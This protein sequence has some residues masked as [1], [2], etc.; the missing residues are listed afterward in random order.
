MIQTI[1]DEIKLRKDYLPTEQIKSVYFGGGTPSLLEAAELD[2]IMETLKTQFSFSKVAEI[3]LEA[4]PD[5]IDSAKLL[6]WRNAGI[7]RLSIGIQS[8][9]QSDLDWMNR[10]HNVN[11]A[12]NSV[13]MSQDA[14]FEN[15]TV[16]LI[17]GLPDLSLEEWEVHLEKVTSMGIDHISSYCLTVE[18]RTKLNSW[19]KQGKIKPSDE[20]AQSDQFL[21]MIEYLASK[22]FEQYEI[23][24]FAR[25]GRYAVHNTAYWTG[26]PYLGIG[27]SAHSFNGF[28]RRWNIANNS[29]YIRSMGVNEDWFFT[30]ELTTMDRWNEM[31]LTGLRTIFGLHFSSLAEISPITQEWMTK[32]C[33]FEDCGWLMI[34]QNKIILTKEGRLKADYIASEL[35]LV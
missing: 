13:R 25:S 29:A 35:F 10:A 12:E 16:D 3:T 24:N 1:I 27:P 32:V 33:E 30:E 17:Y 11:Q 34:A 28:E 26:A 18:D 9:R 2:R 15:L 31:V 14:G 8:F 19:V 4:N 20:A 23:S 6:S 7:N 21:F 5:D 22:G